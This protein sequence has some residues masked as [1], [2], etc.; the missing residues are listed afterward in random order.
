MTSVSRWV[1]GRS[2][3]RR[4]SRSRTLKSAST[5]ATKIATSRSTRVRQVEVTRTRTARI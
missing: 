2:A 5:P 4:F 3:A 1:V